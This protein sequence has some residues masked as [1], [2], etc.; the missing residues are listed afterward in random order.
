MSTT[1]AADR[2]KLSVSMP[3]L[4][5]VPGGKAMAA[6]LYYLG[7][8][9][10]AGDEIHTHIAAMDADGNDVLPHTAAPGAMPPCRGRRLDEARRGYLGSQ[11]SSN[12]CSYG[13]SREN[14]R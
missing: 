12:G 10:G 2:T 4:S 14:G 1:A 8:R 9:P 3:Q 13:S 11:K 7:L 6:L 5:V